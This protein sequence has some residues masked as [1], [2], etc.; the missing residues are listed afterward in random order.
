MSFTTEVCYCELDPA[1]LLTSKHSESANVSPVDIVTLC[2]RGKPGRP[3]KT[4]N[5]AF[6]SEAFRPGRNLSVSKIAETL[7]MDRKTLRVEMKCNGITRAPF[8]TISDDGLDDLVKQHKIK[9]PNAGIRYI[10]GFLFANN[11]RIQRHQIISSLGRVDA[12]AKVARRD[13]EIKRGEYHNPR[14]NAVWHLDG[15]HKLGPWGVVIHG[16]TD[17]YDRLVSILILKFV[18]PYTG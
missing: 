15:H 14:P 5:K 16:I 4:V 3:R 11:L 2:R 8:S 9:Q 17:G 18:P 12:V 10:R 1:T 13:R 7:G 6:L